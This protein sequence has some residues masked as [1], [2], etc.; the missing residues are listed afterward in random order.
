ME[1]VVTTWALVGSV[2]GAVACG[3]AGVAICF[4]LMQDRDKNHDDRD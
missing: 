4:V 3:V 2:L 1:L